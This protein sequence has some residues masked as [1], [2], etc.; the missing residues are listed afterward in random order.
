MFEVARALEPSVVFIDEIDALCRWE[1]VVVGGGGVI[2]MGRR[3]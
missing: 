2:A 3:G 1:E